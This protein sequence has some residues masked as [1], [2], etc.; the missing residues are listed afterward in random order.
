M[1]D[2]IIAANPICRTVTD[3]EYA[4]IAS[5]TVPIEAKDASKIDREQSKEQSLKATT[6][7]SAD[8]GLDILKIIK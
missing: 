8:I 4:G 5:L 2:L 1:D 7:K 6:K 3:L